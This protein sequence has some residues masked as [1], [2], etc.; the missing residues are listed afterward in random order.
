MSDT[1]LSLSGIG[2]VPLSARGLTERL[3]PIENGTLRRTV[4]GTLVDTTLTSHR[5]YGLTISATDVQPP[6]FAGVWAG[7]ATTVQCVTELSKK[8]TLTAGA[9]DNVTLDRKPVTGSGR[10][11]C[12]LSEVDHLT[13][14]VTFAEVTGGWV[15]DVD[16]NDTD[17][18]GEAYVFFR[19]ELDCMVVRLNEDTDEYAA[20]PGWTLELLEV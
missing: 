13:S 20:A 3:A 19:P 10:A 2:V 7:Q 9:A 17:L 1:N 8:I 11:I 18:A 6:A 14:D 12:R 4:N 15:A 5:K 16:F